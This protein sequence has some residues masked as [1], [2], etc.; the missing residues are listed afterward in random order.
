MMCRLVVIVQ[1]RLADGRWGNLARDRLVTHS[2]ALEGVNQMSGPVVV[3][4][5]VSTGIQS[6]TAQATQWTWAHPDL[7][8]K[9]PQ[10]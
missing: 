1:I 3:V 8:N 2:L 7:E 10:G 6:M 9:A 5:L 4:Y